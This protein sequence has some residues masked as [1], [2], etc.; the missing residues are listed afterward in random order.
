MQLNQQHQAKAPR[1]ATL[2]RALTVTTSAIEYL[3]VAGFNVI[4]ID[5]FGARP[6]IQVER[7]KLTD[8]LIERGHACYYKWQKRGGEHQRFGQFQTGDCRVIWVERGH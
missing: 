3:G 2:H 6:T 5:V 8:D 4:G 7:C 1:I